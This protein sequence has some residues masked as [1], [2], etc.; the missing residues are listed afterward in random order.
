MNTK[1]NNTTT[2]DAFSLTC[3]GI[4]MLGSL[5]LFAYQLVSYTTLLG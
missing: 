4:F 1:T 2:G 5:A 3:F